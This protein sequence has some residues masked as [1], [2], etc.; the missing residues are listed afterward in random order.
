MFSRVFPLIILG[1]FLTAPFAMAQTVETPIKF[2]ERYPFRQLSPAIE[3][4]EGF[5]A[6]D[7][8]LQDV[9]GA[10][11]HGIDFVVRKRKAFVPFEVYAAHEGVVWQG[12][13]PS[14]GNYV[15]IEK[16]ASARVR[17]YT[18]YA[19]LSDIPVHIPQRASRYGLPIVAGTF[20]GKAGTSGDTKGNPQLHFELQHRDMV[21]GK[22]TRIDPYGVY[23]RASS[24]RY[25]QPGKTLMGLPHFWLSDAPRFAQ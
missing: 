17:Y 7:G 21:T 3:L 8:A 19:H 16:V 2:I 14:W 23:D 12:T 20:L 24:K 25:P 11:H 6:Y 4:I 9:P 22:W 18:I 13:G 1:V 10:A 15:M 5:S